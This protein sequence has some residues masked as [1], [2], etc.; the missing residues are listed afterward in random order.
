MPKISVI[1][2]VYNM[3]DSRILGKAVRS[4]QN[5]TYKDWELIICDDG[6]TDHTWETLKEIVRDDPRIFCIHHNKNHKAGYARN[7]CIHAARGQYIAI[8]DADDLS[9]P[10]RLQK[11][12]TYLKKHPNVAFVGC[13]GEFFIQNV[14]DDGE[15]YWFCRHPKPKDFLFSLPFVHASLMF[16]QEVLRQTG[17]YDCSKR[18]VRVEDYELLLR[19]YQE[20]YDGKNLSE[21]L[22]YIRRDE[23]QY[24]RRKYRYRFHEAY[25]KYQYFK[26]L[27]LMPKGMLYAAKPLLAGLVPVRLRTALQKKYYMRNVR[28]I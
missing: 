19:L 4:I 23:N 27:G 11:Q 6:S 1:M 21:V 22:Y 7:A 20:G 9:D 12:Y 26:K 18:T 28:K 15:L 25:I 8:M 3:Q 16:R 24:R 14:G 13:R 17:G 10:N 2:A 5:Q